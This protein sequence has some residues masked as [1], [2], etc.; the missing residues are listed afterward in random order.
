MWNKPNYRQ[1]GCNQIKGRLLT[2]RVRVLRLERRYSTFLVYKPRITAGQPWE[3][4]TT[5]EETYVTLGQL[6]L[7]PR[8]YIRTATIKPTVLKL[9]SLMQHCSPA[10]K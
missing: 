3:T 5:A 8:P 10:T 4:T 2:S 7:A 6:H 1:K 9:S